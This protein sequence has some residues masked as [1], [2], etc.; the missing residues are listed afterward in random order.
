MLVGDR[1][2]LREFSE[3]DLA[4]FARY[5]A[6]PEVARYQSWESYSLEDAK[7][8]YVAQLATRFG[9][10]GSWHQIAIA[11]KVS[12]VL[13]GDCALHFRS[14]EE[15]EI[16]FTLAPGWQR[17]GFAREAVSLLLDHAFG[18]MRMRRAL[19]AMDAENVQAQKLLE[20]LG[21]RREAIRDVVFKGKEGK[22]FDFVRNSGSS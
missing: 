16:G 17:Q 13:V 22:E 10:T 15:L 8:L 11:D 19:A 7:R 20:V 14:A 9:T 4:E 3:R 21:F 1:V 18:A 6:H 12:D 2:R 5:R